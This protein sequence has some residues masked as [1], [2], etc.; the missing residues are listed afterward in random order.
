MSLQGSLSTM[1]LPDL[2]Q[3]IAAVRKTG[4]LELLRGKGSKRIL[5]REGRVAACASD[6]PADRLGHFLVSRGRITVAA[7][8]DALAR[9]ESSGKHLGALLVEG[10]LLTEE[11]LAHHLEAK[12][13]ETLIS[14]FDWHDATFT[15]HEGALPE[16]YVLPLN[17]RVEELLLRGA[18][19][20]DEAKRIDAV[21]HDAGIVLSPTGKRPPPEVFKNRM[22]RGIYASINGTRTVAEILLHAHGAEFLVKKFLFELFR[23]GM[24]EIVEVRAVGGQDEP[25]PVPEPVMAA[26]AAP[27]PTLRPPAAAPPAAKALSPRDDPR[28]VQAALDAARRLQERGELDAAL[29]LLNAVH[30][31]NPEDDALRRL[32][33]DAEVAFVDKAWKHYVPAAKVPVLTRPVDSLTGEALSPQEVFLLS[34]VDG[35]W[36]VKSIIQVSPIREVDA[37][38]TLKKLRERGLIELREPS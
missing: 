33:L 14:V 20:H 27:A 3:W 6:E 26:A 2:L 18:K 17:L 24:V 19:R 13:E 32:V 16:G 11:D 10:G 12:A 31:A 35:T 36:D 34:R 1:P 38:R 28:K 15:W 21:F 9:Q 30:R 23:S 25:A 5:F 4:T 22:A 29:D 8:R 7:L 37:L